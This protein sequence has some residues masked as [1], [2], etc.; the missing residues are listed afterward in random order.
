MRIR[1]SKEDGSLRLVGALIVVGILA[2]GAMVW[3]KSSKPVNKTSDNVVA[4]ALDGKD[5]TLDAKQ[6]VQKL[7]SS[8]PVRRE[9]VATAIEQTTG[10]ALDNTYKQSI[11]PD[12]VKGKADSKVTVVEYEDFACV[13]CQQVHSYVD[14][15]HAEYSDRVRF[16][17]RNFNLKFP[18]SDVVLVAGE[19]A[20]H[21]AGEAAFWQMHDLLFSNDMWTGYTVEEKVRERTLTDYAKRIGLDV[22]KFNTARR[23]ASSNGV[24][25]KLERDA[26]LAGKDGV[27][28]TPTMIVNGKKIDGGLT[29]QA[30]KQ[31]IDNAL[32]NK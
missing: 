14:K 10:K 9:D 21:L 1:G 26:A 12:H 32:D 31:A 22:S 15:I 20:A 13:H 4:R 25:E 28:G 29:Y 19:S 17:Y 2:I 11:I 7:D 8:R 30:M 18:N 27:N 16:I 5:V 24:K 3:Y 6:I 23:D